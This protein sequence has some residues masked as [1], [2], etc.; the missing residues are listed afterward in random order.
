MHQA[1]FS[2][3]IIYRWY[4]SSKKSCTFKY[5]LVNDDGLDKDVCKTFYLTTLGFHPKNDSIIT[6]VMGRSPINAI[7]PNTDKRGILSKK[8]NIFENELISKH[9]ESYEPTISHF[10]CEHAPNCRFLPSDLS[11]VNMHKYF[12]LQDPNQA[13]SYHLYQ[14]LC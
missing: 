5:S 9:I 2:T 7:H 10:R 14:Q 6:N 3:K 13:C 1:R 4:P 11:I 12:L 8:K